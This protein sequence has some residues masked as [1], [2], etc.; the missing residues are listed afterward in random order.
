MLRISDWRSIENFWSGSV[1]T[2]RKNV[3]QD[4]SGKIGSQLSGPGREVLL[5]ESSMRMVHGL[6][7]TFCINSGLTTDLVHVRN[8]P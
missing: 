6:Q 7:E 1:C 5:D 3:C 4:G 8:M 2:I